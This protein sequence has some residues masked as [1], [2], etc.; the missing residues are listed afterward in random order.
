VDHRHVPIRLEGS[1]PLHASTTGGP[2]S[3][4]TFPRYRRRRLV[5]VGPG[6]SVTSG[7]GPPEG[8]RGREMVTLEGDDIEVL[9]LVAEGLTTA[10]IARRM[11]L[12]ERTVRRRLVRLCQR[13]GV[14]TPVEAVVLAVRHGVI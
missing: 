12:N 8:G 11:N 7:Q 10:G 2:S 14:S 9:A 6:G 13:L 5:L 3:L 1:L 4:L